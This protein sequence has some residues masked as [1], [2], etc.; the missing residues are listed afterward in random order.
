MVSIILKKQDEYKAKK[1]KEAADYKLRVEKGKREAVEKELKEKEAI[2]L[3]AEQERI[4]AAKKAQAA[5]DKEKL[6]MLASNISDLIL[7][8]LNSPEADQI[9]SSAK[10]LLDKVVVFIKEKTESL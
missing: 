2:E 1:E 3:K 10:N 5:P 6:L 7:P 4:L 9:L 8:K